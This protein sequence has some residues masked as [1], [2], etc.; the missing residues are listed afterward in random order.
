MIRLDRLFWYDAAVLAVLTIIVVL[1]EI[2]VLA[3]LAGLGWLSCLFR[4]LYFLDFWFPI[5]NPNPGPGN[6]VILHPHQKVILH[7]Y[8][9]P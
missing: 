7:P 5:H 8:Q 1:V 6:I 9:L 3:V 4:I 2:A